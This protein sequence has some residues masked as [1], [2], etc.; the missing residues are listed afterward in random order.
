MSVLAPLSHALA[1][2]L[3]GAH[4][5]LTFAGSDASWLLAIAA[6]VVLVRL[7]LLPLTIRGVRHAHASARARPQLQALTK[8]YTEKN[9]KSSPTQADMMAMMEERRKINEEHGVPRFAMLAAFAQLPIFLALYHL[10]FDVSRDT[11]V[12]AMNDS[13]VS[14]LG[15]AT[16]LGTPLTG[17]GY[18]SG[19]TTHL[20]ITLGLAA[21]AAL[22]SYVT[23]RLWVLPNM[24]RTGMPDSMLRI[25]ELMP[26]ISAGGMLL[27][28]S[29]VPLALLVYWVIS[30][31]WTAGQA[32][33]I[34]RWFPTP[35]SP[36]AEKQLQT[37]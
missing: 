23:Q 14:S 17:H 13:L 33:V 9:A 16:F 29:S 8:K 31:L 22:V 3:A 20:V 37:S 30:G 36:A 34:H 15:A 28:G 10:L 1:A 4:H 7:V 27:A 25:Q 32:A 5:V 24:V 11:A 19:D 35:G 26:V 6:V 12:G 18:L 2:A 21:T